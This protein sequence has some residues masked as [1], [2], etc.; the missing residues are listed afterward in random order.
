MLKKTISYETLDGETVTEDF[1]FNLSKSELFE[2][3]VSEEGGME[4]YLKRIIA[5]KDGKTII[6]EFKKL[7]LMTYGVKSQD[8]KRFIK[9]DQ[10]REEFEQSPA[11]D[12]LFFELCTD[13]EAGAEFVNAIVPSDLA[14]AIEKMEKQERT[15]GSDTV[16]EL[17]QPEQKKWDDYT[18]AELLTLPQEEFQRLVPRNTKDMTH[19][20]LQIAYRRKNS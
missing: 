7:I 5:S 11:F 19:E 4:A 2:L 14:E 16:V 15:Q 10:V 8:G 13:S 20:Q 6:S 12:K 3:E 17:P 18:E 1:Y 9:N